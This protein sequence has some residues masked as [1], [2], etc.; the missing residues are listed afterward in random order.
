MN[1]VTDFFVSNLILQAHL[2]QFIVLSGMDRLV[3]F[4]FF[5]ATENHLCVDFMDDG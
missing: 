2:E 4:F 3:F 5:L 1:F